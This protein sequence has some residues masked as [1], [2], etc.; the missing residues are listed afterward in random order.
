[1]VNDS[2]FRRWIQEKWFE[3]KYEC[4]DWKTKSCKDAQEYFNKN[5]WF[6][7]ALYKRE[8]K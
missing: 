4:L 1:M 2:K 5:K 8:V 3:H 6:L 7:K